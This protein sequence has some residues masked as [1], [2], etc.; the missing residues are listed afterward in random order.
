MI[1]TISPTYERDEIHVRHPYEYSA[2]FVGL[3]FIQTGEH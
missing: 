2:P 1:V 3:V